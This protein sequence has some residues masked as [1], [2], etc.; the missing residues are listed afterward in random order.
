[1]IHDAVKKRKGA[2]PSIKQ[3]SGV[4]NSLALDGKL[5]MK[6]VWLVFAAELQLWRVKVVHLRVAQVQIEQLVSGHS[7]SIIQADAEPCSTVKDA[8]ALL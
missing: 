1:M 2:D 6:P 4:R 7:S 3:K 5:K 8:T